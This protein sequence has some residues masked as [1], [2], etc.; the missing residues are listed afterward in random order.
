MGSEAEAAWI[1]AARGGDRDAFGKL[2]ELHQDAVM[3]AAH[4]M[5]GNPEDAEDVAQETFIRAYRSLG[6]FAGGSSFKT[7][8]LVIATN[9][10]R[11]LA[12]S[13]RAKKRDSRVLRIESAEDRERIDLPDRPE[14]SSP[15]DQA[16][17][18]EL[19]EALEEAIATLDEESR[20]LIILRDL[21]GGSYEEIAA[22]LELPL[23]TVKSRIHR[24]R[25]ELREKLRK[26]L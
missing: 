2:V 23:G 5:T 20:S 8:L 3:T 10:S 13:R 14:R 16:L 15:E 21:L 7:W 25:L 26:Y 1:C 12:A 22:A 18:S 4:Y 24:A 9:S 11:S 6:T 17:R 19:K